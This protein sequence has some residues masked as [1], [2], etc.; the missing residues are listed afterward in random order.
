MALTLPTQK[1]PAISTNP[2]FLIIY[3]RPKVGN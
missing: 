3:G 1:I 2:S